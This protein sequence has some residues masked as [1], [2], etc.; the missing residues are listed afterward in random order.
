M[1]VTTPVRI[2]E[3]TNNINFRQ[4]FCLARSSESALLSRVAHAKS[5]NPKKSSATGNRTRVIRVT[6]G[7]TNHYTITDLL[8]AGRGPNRLGE[9]Y[10]VALATVV[11]PWNN[12][13]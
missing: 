3:G 6:G 12:L 8:Y 4:S 11:A 9:V 10:F 7:Y 1:A 2:R 5:G 13:L